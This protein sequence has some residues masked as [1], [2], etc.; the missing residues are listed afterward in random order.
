[1]GHKN[2]VAQQNIPS[3]ELNALQDLYTATNGDFW[4][5]VQPNGTSSLGAPWNFSQ[6]DPNPCAEL[7][8]GV[9]CGNCNSSVC[10]VESLRLQSHNISGH[11]QP[12]LS[13]LTYLQS[14]DL[15]DN[16]I[17]GSVPATFASLQY[18]KDL[19]LRD[20]TLYGHLPTWLPQLRSLVNLNLS[21]NFFRDT[22][23]DSYY[24]MTNLTTLEM[25]NNI[26]RGSISD[27]GLSQLVNL[28]MLNLG[29]NRLNGTLPKSI[30]LL[31][32][33][34]S[35]LLVYNFLSGTIP[36]EI[37]ESRSLTVFTVFRNR[38]NGTIPASFG[39]MTQLESL[40]LG[41]NF[42]TRTLPSSLG[43]LTS[44]RTLNA[45][46]NYLVGTFPE[47]VCNLSNLTDIQFYE[48]MLE[49]TL[50]ACFRNLT[51]LMQVVLGSNLFSSS[52]P[53][54]FEDMPNLFYLD[55]THNMF[56]GFLPVGE[57]ELLYFYQVSHN[58][59]RGNISETLLS[60]SKNLHYFV[61]DKNMLTG[62]VS[63]VVGNNRLLNVFAVEINFLEGVIPSSFGKLDRMVE[64]FLE[65]NLLSGTVPSVLGN[66]SLLV[67]L[68][69]SYNLLSSTLPLALA[70]LSNLD[71]LYLSDNK[72][73]NGNLDYFLTVH[74]Y[75]FLT[76]VDISHNRFTG[77]L[78]MS[79]FQ[80]P[81]LRT[82]D[83]SVNCF[84]GTL[85]E[86]LCQ[87]GN[88]SVLILDGLSTSPACRSR[89]FPKAFPQLTAFTLNDIKVS[90]SI[91]ACLFS[92]PTL[93]VLHLSGNALSG[94]LP[95]NVTYEHAFTD[96]IASHN[97]LSGAIPANLQRHPMR[98]FHLSYNRFSGTL[99]DD[100]L[101]GGQK[102]VHLQINRLSGVV[103][104]SLRNASDIKLLDGNIFSCDFNR[105]ELPKHDP[106]YDTY[107]CGSDGVDGSLYAWLGLCSLLLVISLIVLIDVCFRQRMSL[108]RV[109]LCC[110]DT[111]QS[112]LA[113]LR[114]QDDNTTIN[115]ERVFSPVFRLAVFFT[116]VRK[117]SLFIAAYILLVL[118]PMYI[119][120]SKNTKT[121][122]NEYG[123]QISAILLAGNTATVM[124]FIGYCVLMLIHYGALRR[125]ND[126]L[127]SY[128]L[129]NQP[130]SSES[131]SGKTEE[132]SRGST[133]AD[134]DIGGNGSDS[135]SGQKNRSLRA[136]FR[137][138]VLFLLNLIIMVLID[139][140][141]VFIVLNKRSS[142][143]ITTQ[144]F[145]ALFKLAWNEVAL[146]FLIP[147]TKIDWLS[148]LLS[149]RRPKRPADIDGDVPM[150]QRVDS[151]SR[152]ISS[153][154]P[155]S[156]THVPEA[157]SKAGSFDSVVSFASSFS[158]EFKSKTTYTR[159]DV[160]MV[161]VLILLNNIL[162]PAIAIACVSSSCFYNVFVALDSV[163]DDYSLVECAL[164]LVNF[165]GT[166]CVQYGIFQQNVSY[167]PPYI[168]SYNCASMITLNF[169]SVFIYMFIAAGFLLPAA[170]LAVHTYYH[171]LPH[172]H[173][174]KEFLA[175]HLP[176]VYR[177]PR[178]VTR[179]NE[180]LQLFF[181]E[182]S[183]VRL[184]NYLAIVLAFGSIYPPIA[185]MGALTIV[186]VTYTDEYILGYMLQ[187]A[188]QCGFTWY[189][190]R[191]K[192]QCMDTHVVWIS[193]ARR[194]IIYV[195]FVL[196]YLVFDTY[197]YD[198]GWR[199]GMLLVTGFFAFP[200]IC[201][202]IYLVVTGKTNNFFSPLREDQDLSDIATKTRDTVESES[203]RGVSSSNS[204]AR[205]SAEEKQEAVETIE[206]PLR[207]SLPIY[208]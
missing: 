145:L 198:A 22:I 101:A 199:G 179:Y 6:P 10:H 98:E 114:I 164:Y 78:P 33:L 121:Y 195:Y 55:L 183:V 99:S 149:R 59:F 138:V 157:N 171:A 173:K 76:N 95:K 61:V 178:S 172:N 64:L 137:S 49:S 152:P 12:S 81:S 163:T 190:Y 39:N 46:S 120:L 68:D 74:H 72:F 167:D 87:P 118:M 160:N 109:L 71:A 62:T 200:A 108:Y 162:V 70:N 28:R 66:M 148:L 44:L 203:P 182:K 176:E 40:I 25:A 124:L 31:P 41:D 83:A 142:V 45:A 131:L 177:Y 146:W 140:A 153:S 56:T 96:L 57:W 48:N 189:R 169:S 150:V 141:Y 126:I 187:Q 159:A 11:L 115:G 36:V 193:I 208:A 3:S 13:N 94:T 181:K 104:N 37:T 38:L 206:N 191:L 185:L 53:T 166:Y 30:G 106:K 174:T 196:G 125:M 122:D 151:G 19:N 54:M 91:P 15:A 139:V 29:S 20:N 128:G 17:Q 132:L 9:V 82:I 155:F 65:N 7:W 192:Q 89:I 117:L 165:R 180:H 123:W 110:K 77:S 205:R 24:D 158:E 116:E 27:S 4:H 175:R 102:V 184:V 2:K 88:L 207:Q 100:F 119:A 154:R 103:P 97:F 86:G 170:K 79:V 161:T 113:M 127:R 18:L 1:M 5:W 34:T 35:A 75:P 14:L 84:K 47:W 194:I 60:T 73:S 80:I 58:M 42:F 90:G 133:Q 69:L 21:R 92:I 135:S 168:Y 188:E 43:Q 204:S 134:K 202:F 93:R 112:S 26:L 143:V 111:L 144:V 197:G 147:L 201:F 105:D 50:P 32:N 51:K 107:V 8:Q 186:V 85:S 23:P 130:A 16:F 129:P 136:G 63:E 52:V 156:G 67:F